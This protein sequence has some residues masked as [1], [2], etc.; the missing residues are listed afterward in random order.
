MRKFIGVSAAALAV[1]IFSAN[2]ALAQVA[3]ADVNLDSND[4]ELVDLDADVDLLGSDGDGVDAD[5]DVTVGGDDNLADG[6]VDLSLGDD[7][8]LDG[9]VDATIGGGD[10]VNANVNLGVGGS[11]SGSG[12]GGGGAT[13]GSLST[14]GA[15]VVGT[16]GTGSTG[17]GSGAECIGTGSELVAQLSGISY[18]SAAVSGW[19]SAGSAQLIPVNLCPSVDDQMSVGLLQQVAPTVPAIGA[20]LNQSSYDAS[21]IVG[22][23]QSGSVL[24]VYVN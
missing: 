4:G 5:A 3:D 22:I 6:D 11:S 18:S 2:P 24:N 7:D 15:T 14:G 23:V 1:A 10:G 13:G 9:S 21:D 20:A 8:T 16:G 17:T 19:A 12:S